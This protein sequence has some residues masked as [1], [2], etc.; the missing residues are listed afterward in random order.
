MG[1]DY[2][3]IDKQFGDLIVIDLDHVDTNRATYWRCECTCGN[4]IVVRRDSLVG[5]KTTSCGCRKRGV[6]RENLIGN[7]YGYLTVTDIDSDRSH[8][9]THW[10]CECD[11]GN[12]VSVRGASLK[13]GH[14]RSCGCIGHGREMDDLIGKRF[15]RL[16]VV[17]FDHMDKYYSSHWV[18]RCDC[19]SEIVVSRGNLVKG[20]AK[21]CGCYK[22]DLQ[23]ELKTIHGE[24]QS[25]LHNIW[26]NMKQRCGNEKN[27]NYQSYGKRGIR[28]CDEWIDD[29]ESFRDWALANGYSD[30]LTLDRRNNDDI[31][32]PDNCRW[33]DRYT[34]MNNRRNTRYL[35]YNDKTHSISEWARILNVTPST[36]SYRVNKGDMGLLDE[37]FDGRGER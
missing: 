36:L 15:G 28:V 34:Q 27:T 7:K 22:R 16:V 17:E 32:S 8:S 1:I 30:E 26:E 23:R 6:E 5:G 19:G 2:S 12:Y 10:I 24:S 13:N 25:R 11:C 18:C 29:Y 4:E 31:Y 14:T 9:Q 21:S 37:Y 33:T 3:I 20:R 35:T